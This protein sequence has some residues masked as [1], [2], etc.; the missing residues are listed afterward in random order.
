LERDNAKR[1]EIKAMLEAE[2]TNNT[3]PYQVA[4]TRVDMTID[5]LGGNIKTGN[6][7]IE[8]KG[9]IGAE[10]TIQETKVKD[11][12]TTRDNLVQ[13]QTEEEINLAAAK[14]EFEKIAL[15]YATISKEAKTILDRNGKTSKIINPVAQTDVDNAR[16][17]VY[18]DGD[19]TALVQ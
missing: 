7:L 14:E 8:E 16:L 5:R 2:R 18:K 11:L 9:A 13:K 4:K 6:E 3:I 15:A 19:D 17:I 12:K 1:N 10:K